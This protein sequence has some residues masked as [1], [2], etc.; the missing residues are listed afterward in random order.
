M[1]FHINLPPPPSI[2]LL[3]ISADAPDHSNHHCNIQLYRSCHTSPR[4][5][6]ERRCYYRPQS[7]IDFSAKFGRFPRAFRITARFFSNFGSIPSST[8]LPWI[9][10]VNNIVMTYIRGRYRFQEFTQFFGCLC[11]TCLSRLRARCTRFFCRRPTEF[12]RN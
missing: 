3:D 2:P 7:Y 1:P 6:D 12:N 5:G 8:T 10:D 4:G 9:N 11:D